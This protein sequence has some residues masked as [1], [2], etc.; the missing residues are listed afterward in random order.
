MP[1]KQHSLPSIRTF[2]NLWNGC[3]SLGERTSSLVL[4]ERSFVLYFA[5]VVM[6]TVDKLVYK[7]K[8]ENKGMPRDQDR[9]MQQQQQQQHQKQQQQQHQQRYNNNTSLALSSTEICSIT[10]YHLPRWWSSIKRGSKTRRYSNKLAKRIAYILHTV[11]WSQMNSLVAISIATT[12]IATT[13]AIAI[14]I[15]TT[16]SISAISAV[17]VKKTM[18]KADS[19]SPQ[20]VVEIFWCHSHHH[21][22]RRRRRRCRR[23]HHHYCRSKQIRIRKWGTILLSPPR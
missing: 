14:A 16:T 21:R 11:S 6:F 23:R 13:I 1:P 8:N 22:R 18:T 7:E 15:A 12:A 9:Q 10:I 19:F 17:I 20:C 2:L 4:S 3:L 5:T